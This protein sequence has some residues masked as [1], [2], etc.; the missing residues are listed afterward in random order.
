MTNIDSVNPPAVP[1]QP[2]PCTNP[3]VELEVEK[4]LLTLKHNR[5]NRLRIVITP[6]SCRGTK[7]RIE[8]QRTSGGGWLP[9][10]KTRSLLWLARVAGKFKLRGVA[11]IDGSEVMSPEKDVE[12]QFPQYSEIAGDPVVSGGT[13][14]EW[15][16]TLRDCRER[17]VNRRRERGF[18]ININTRINRYTFTN[19]VKG[20]WVGP[21]D[22]ADVPL[23]TRPAD[24]PASPAANERGAKYPVCSF[25]THTPTEF[26]AMYPGTRG[27]GPSV[28]DNNIDTSDQVPGMVYDYVE[29]PAGSGSIPMGHPKGSA[30]TRYRSLGLNRRPTP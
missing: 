9:L 19:R 15:A 11:T 1:V 16:A 20:Q 10:S 25:H 3:Q 13:S 24:V 17:P 6:A 21:A 28:P 27:V 22:G 14:R 8:I 12:V 5:A 29:S 26:R 4:P 2:P 18:W 30:A 7:F 23:P